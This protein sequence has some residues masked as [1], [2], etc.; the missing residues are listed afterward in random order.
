[1]IATNGKKNLSRAVVKRILSPPP[2]KA[3]ELKLYFTVGGKYDRMMDGKERR[4]KMIIFGIT[5]TNELY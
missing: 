3:K 2:Y 5:N 4:V 1:M